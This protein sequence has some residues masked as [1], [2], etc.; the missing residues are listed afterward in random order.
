MDKANIGGFN[1]KEVINEFIGGKEV[2]EVEDNKTVR[3]AT[4][5][6]AFDTMLSTKDIEMKTDLSNPMIVE[7]SRAQTILAV[8]E[9]PVMRTFVDFFTKYS[10][11]KNRKGREE[12]VKLTTNSNMMEEAVPQ[13]GFEKIL[14]RVI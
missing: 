13:G 2:A 3:Q 12:I 9:I 8:K 4:I 10:V 14:N 5:E 1:R 6:K 7:L 11:S